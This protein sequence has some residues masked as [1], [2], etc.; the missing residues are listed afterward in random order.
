MYSMFHIYIEIFIFI[1][2]LLQ[3]WH[4]AAENVKSKDPKR[5]LREPS[6]GRCPLQ[7][8][9]FQSEGTSKAGAS[10]HSWW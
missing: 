3:V 8:S 6:G 2:T 4:P 9:P 5:D 7:G 10:E 1:Y